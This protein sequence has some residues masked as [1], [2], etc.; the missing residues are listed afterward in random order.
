MDTYALLREAILNKHQVTCTYHGYHREVCPHVL[1]T[2]KDG[3]EQALTFQFAGES[4]SD[5]PPDGQ[6]RCLVVDE[7]ENAEMRPGEWH[8]GESHTQ[9]QYCVAQIDV[10]VA[11]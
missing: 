11:Y 2:N 4:S 10:E 8:T 9:P 1:G 5:L 3:R 7:I 6:W